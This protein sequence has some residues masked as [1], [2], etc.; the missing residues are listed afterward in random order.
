MVPRDAS[1]PN[2][3]L[4]VAA[5]FLAS[6]VGTLAFLVVRFGYVRLQRERSEHLYS[7]R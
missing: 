5:A 6:L 1:S 7:L 3:R 4:D 2:I